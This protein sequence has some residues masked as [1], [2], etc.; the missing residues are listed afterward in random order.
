V[1]PLRLSELTADG[2]ELI[3]MLCL[4]VMLCCVIYVL[5]LCVGVW[6]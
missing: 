6:Y 3:F 4:C 5:C 1:V 2:A